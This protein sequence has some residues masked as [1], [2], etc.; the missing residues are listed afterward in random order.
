MLKAFI[1]TFLIFGAHLACVIAF[2]ENV[3]I[4]DDFDI[5]LSGTLAFLEKESLADRLAVLFGSHGEHFVAVPKMFGLLSYKI[6]GEVS[7]IPLI[8]VGNFLLFFSALAMISGCKTKV[9]GL[10]LPILGI[11]LFIFHPQ[12]YQSS[13]WATAALANMGVIFFAI[14]S[15]YF[16]TREKPALLLSF[17]F[18]LLAFLTQANGL[19]VFGLIAAQCLLTGKRK[20]SLVFLLSFLAFAFLKKHYGPVPTITFEPTNNLNY[21]L[22]LLGAPLS[23]SFEQAITVGTPVLLVAICALAVSF[24]LNRFIFLSLLFFL[25]SAFLASIFR[26]H[27][28]LAGGFVESRYRLISCPIIAFS[29]VT[30]CIG[31]RNINVLRLFVPPLSVVGAICFYGWSWYNYFE[32]YP[33][34][35]AKHS[36]SAVRYRLTGLGLSHP[37]QSVAVSALKESEN[38]KV[39]TLPEVGFS[40]FEQVIRKEKLDVKEGNLVGQFE[41]FINSDQQLYMEG[42]VLA[43]E[44][45]QSAAKI[46][47]RL[48][49][50]DGLTFT[51]PTVQS[52]RPDIALMFQRNQKENSGFTALINKEALPSGNYRSFLV[53]GPDRGTHHFIETDKTL[54]IN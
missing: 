51:V 15:I 31:S 19:L 21:F 38:R 54:T 52:K 35:H 16:A 46:L 30:V 27:L 23:V 12:I 47:I 40:N 50:E 9:H 11:P 32:F 29:L 34:Y 49:H 4:I 37:D 10:T 53:L 25:S 5:F 1:V 22:S 45:V 44:P 8:I 43:L 3:P 2:S 24:K 18:G 48:R 6:F 17:S 13:T 33:L 41:Y 20:C 7:F 28:G 42:F 36:N 14:G 26:V 39:Y